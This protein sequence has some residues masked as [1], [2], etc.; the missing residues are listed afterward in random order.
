M[1]NAGVPAVVLVADDSAT[2]RA[3]L[4]LE[5]EAAGYAV[6]EAADGQAA[7]QQAQDN[8]VS[9]VLLDVEM[10]VLDGHQALAALKADERT[11]DIPVVFL[12]GRGAGQDLVQALREGAHDYLRKPPEPAELLAR[13]GAANRMKELQDE[14]RRRA[15]ELDRV[16]R[17]DHLTGLHNR[18]HVEEQ[19]HATV[20]ACVRHGFPAAVL[21][22]DIDHFKRVNDEH[23]HAAGDEV[24]V[25]VAATLSGSLRTEDIVGRWGGE[26]FIVVAPHTSQ[27]AA[28]V[29]A[30]RLRAAV[31]AST[32]VTVSIGGA[33]TPVASARLLEVADTN[34]YA[35]KA[36]GRNRA[37]ISATP[38][39]VV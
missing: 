13:V 8:E 38:D 10:P 24:L 19:L 29:L 18:R 30:E 11:R 22:L 4:R 7:V 12:S 35:A 17:T 5:L 33:C 28:G 37:V 21:V 3:V 39:A 1:H 31:E 26:E 36:A 34:L 15:E 23:G 9:V 2:V 32:P 16:S 14:L 25:Q 20:A 6:L 27:P